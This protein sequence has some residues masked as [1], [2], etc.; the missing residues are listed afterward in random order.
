MHL[1]CLKHFARKSVRLQ[2]CERVSF[3]LLGS[4]NLVSDKEKNF[5][6]KAGYKN[7]DDLRAVLFIPSS[8]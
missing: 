4:H 8:Q 3:F 2:N 6:N 1:L 5:Q 7:V